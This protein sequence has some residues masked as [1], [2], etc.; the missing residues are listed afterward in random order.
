MRSML[1]KNS[2]VILA[3]TTVVTGCATQNFDKKIESS[4]VDLL[5]EESLM[6]YNTNRLES[7]DVTESD[8]ISKALLACHQKKYAKGTGILE[9]EMHK[10]KTNPFYWN[11]LG[12]CYSL[13][14]EYTKALFYYDL[15]VEALPLIK[16]QSKILAEA[17]LAN[18]IGLVHLNF[19]RYNE[20]FDSFKR[21]STLL[22]NFF[23][24]QFNIAQLFIEFNENDK[25]LEILK[26]LEVKNPDD[27]DLLYSLSLIYFRKNDLDKSYNAISRIKTDYLNR[28]DIVGLY[29]YNLM[30]KNRLTEAR[31]IIEKRL[32]ADEYNQ[33]NKILLEE[34]NLKI[35]EQVK[36]EKQ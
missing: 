8:L 22:P 3:I 17:T 32:Y 15:G 18:N 14:K 26:K 9:T 10:N 20:A 33:R 4:D 6:R 30:K 2:L 12:T 21:S 36:V 13:S 27:I 25:A 1:L 16:D 23:T 34:I 7:M 28:P 29:A 24:P 11:A 31:E 35:K 5:K 19:K